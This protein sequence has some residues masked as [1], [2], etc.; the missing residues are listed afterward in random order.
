V[1]GIV[2]ELNKPYP[3]WTWVTNE[4]GISYWDSPIPIPK[5]H[6]KIYTWNEEMQDW[7]EESYL[8]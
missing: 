5:E 2:D 1:G 8:T 4:V 7:V 6:G 3:S